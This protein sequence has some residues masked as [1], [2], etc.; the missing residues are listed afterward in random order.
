MEPGGG[1]LKGR[2][3]LMRR[4]LMG[5]GWGGRLKGRLDLMGLNLGWGVVCKGGWI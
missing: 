3:D 4:D 5:V 2:C 1:G